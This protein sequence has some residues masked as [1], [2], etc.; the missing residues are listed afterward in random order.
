M[1]KLLLSIAMLVFAGLS[2]AQAQMWK[3]TA[4]KRDAAVLTNKTGIVSPQLFELDINLLKQQL[5]A[6]PMRFS[7][8]KSGVVA[9]FPTSDGQMEHFRM[10]KNSNMDPALQA[11]YPEIQSYL[12]QGVE[13]PSATIYVSV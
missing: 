3:S 13:N 2:L 4:K 1:K 6:S 12:G 9:A 8:G 11:R 5:A 10:L 7:G